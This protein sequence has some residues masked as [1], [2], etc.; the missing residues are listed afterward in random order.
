MGM[1]MMVLGLRVGSARV[2]VIRLGWCVERR[3]LSIQKIEEGGLA[4]A[5]WLLGMMM[6]GVEEGRHVL[7]LGK[8]VRLFQ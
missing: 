6:M 5:R 7:F 8:L 3:L 1:R 2:A 4:V